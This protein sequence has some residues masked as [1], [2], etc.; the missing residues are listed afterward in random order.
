MSSS[1]NFLLGYMDRWSVFFVSGG[2]FVDVSLSSH[3]NCQNHR[4]TKRFT[5][6]K[7]L[8]SDKKFQFRQEIYVG[9][10]S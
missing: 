7:T 2:S 4:I 3:G 6:V 9:F 1:T 8:A 10:N 5:K